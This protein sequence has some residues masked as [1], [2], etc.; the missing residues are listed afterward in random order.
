MSTDDPDAEHNAER[1]RKLR[2]EAL[3]IA[4]T[5]NDPERK[6]LML[7]F[8]DAYGRLAERVELSQSPKE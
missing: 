7:Y 3:T 4:N 2:A 1:W 8:V 6:R 5:M